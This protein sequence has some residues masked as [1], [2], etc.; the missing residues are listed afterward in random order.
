M[1]NVLATAARCEVLTRQG[2]CRCQILTGKGD[3]F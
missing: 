3:K 2:G 1:N